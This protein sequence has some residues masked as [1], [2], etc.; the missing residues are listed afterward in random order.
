MRY[1]YYSIMRP[2][3]VGTYPKSGCG[4]VIEIKNF[5]RREMVDSI[6]RMA[7]GYIEYSEPLTE[8]ELSD[9]ELVAEIQATAG[10]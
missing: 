10:M 5:D 7:W 4:K 9:Y 2:V 6:G 3:S 8:K 1:R